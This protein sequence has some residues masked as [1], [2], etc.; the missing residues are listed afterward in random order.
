MKVMLDEYNVLIDNKT[1]TL[2]PCSD[3]NVVGNKWVFRVKRKKDGSVDKFKARVVAKG[4]NQRHWVDFS[5]TFSPIIKSATI[6]IV[7]SLR[8][9]YGWQLKQMNVNNAF[10]QGKLSEEVYMPQPIGFK[11][12]D[13]PDH[14]CKLNRAIYGL[15]Q[16]PRAWYH[17]LSKF[18]LD[19][20]FTNSTSDA[21]L[22]IYSSK[23]TIMYFLMYVDDLI[24]TGIN[25]SQLNFFV[26]SLSSQFSLKKLGELNY[27]L[28]IEVV[29]TIGGLLL[30]Q[31]KYIKEILEIF[32]H[33]QL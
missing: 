29:R 6:Q 3:Y 32:W 28:G 10:L 15:K 11:E 13:H 19:Y 31:Q 5:E 23:D 2:A 16:A 7:L 18:L 8:L 9:N 22:F 1:W 26:N 33:D 4:F 14:V 25:V 20:G 30:S 27:F 21:S 12:K 24:L 17:V